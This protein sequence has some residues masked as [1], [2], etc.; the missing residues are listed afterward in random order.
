MFFTERGRQL[1]RVMT[2]MKRNER[3]SGDKRGILDKDAAQDLLD[4]S[5]RVKVSKDLARKGPDQSVA[6][7]VIMM[8]AV[9]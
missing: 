1:T 4:R 6:T 3:R 2:K 8:K 5:T 7:L 9:L